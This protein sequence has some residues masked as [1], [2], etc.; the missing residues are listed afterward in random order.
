MCNTKPQRH[1]DKVAKNYSKMITQGIGGILKRSEVESLMRLL[2]PNVG[3]D[4]LDVGC[5]SGFYA[6]MVKCAGANVFCVDI[7]PRMVE[8]V[9]QAGLEAEAHDI[10]LMNLNRSFD[11]ILCA[12]P[13]EFCQE[14]VTALNNLRRHLRRQGYLVVSVLTVSLIGVAYLAYH[15]IH[16]YRINLFTLRR[17]VSLLHKAGFRAETIEKP[18]S[19]LY[20]IKARP[21]DFNPLPRG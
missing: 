4:I 10:H 19:F 15:M 21:Y 12:G 8:V 2:S 16:G 6:E 14:P 7:S 13:L 1:Y 20:V 5:G 11:K 3:E 9:R 17:I 18:T